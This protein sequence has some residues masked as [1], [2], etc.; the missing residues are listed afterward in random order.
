MK[1]IFMMILAISM[2]LSL[3]A[4]GTGKVDSANQASDSSVP[5]EE[6]V[7]MSPEAVPDT[8]EPVMINPS[9]DKYTWY[10][11]DYVGKNVASFGYTS[12]GGDRRDS[13]GA[14][15]LALIL[16]T[17]DGSYIDIEDENLLK[18]YVVTAQDLAPN[19]EL[20][21]TFMK[22]SDGEEY[23]NLVEYQ[24]YENIVLGVKKIG[25]S[26]KGPQELMVIN[27]SPDKYTWYIRN[28]IGRNL[29][30]CGYASLGGDFRDSYGSSS[31]KLV[32]IAD[33]GG[34]IDPEDIESLQN[35]I[36]KNQNITPNTELKLEF[37][38]KS[39]GSEYDNLVDNQSIE[40]I[41][42]YVSRIN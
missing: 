19:T 25:D 7:S 42:L 28:Y 1:R 17:E 10:I 14:A 3:V 11:K 18:E 38:K 8:H 31:L 36:V 30:T 16:V 5:A 21:L 13:Y 39:D 2:I 26:S 32:I 20:K 9:P 27:P 37:M 33:D 24:N 34:Y 15:S 41:E 22:D 12:L 29:A 6:N 40:E 23:S 4:C 35:F